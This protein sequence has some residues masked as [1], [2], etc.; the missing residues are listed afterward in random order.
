MKYATFTTSGRIACAYNDETVI[1]V[2][3]DAYM[4]T[5][6]QWEH[7]TTLVLIDGEV[8]ITSPPDSASFCQW[9]GIEWVLDSAAQEQAAIAQ[10][11]SLRDSLLRSAALR[12]APLQD[13]MELEEATADE[14]DRLRAWRRYRVQLSRVEQQQGFPNA[15]EWPEVPAPRVG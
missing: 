5:S 12:M 9:N 4:L 3:A 8:V 1:E 15:I 7:R 2:P 14:L 13:A 11:F 10:V 6:E